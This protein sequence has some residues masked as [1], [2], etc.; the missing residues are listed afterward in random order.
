[1]LYRLSTLLLLAA[2]TWTLP[3]AA[4]TNGA[5][6][7]QDALA[8]LLE[9][10]AT[11]LDDLPDVYYDYY[12]LRSDRDNTV[13]AR[14]AFYNQIG[15]GDSEL[16]KRRSL[17]VELI[18]RRLM[19]EVELGDT[20]IVPTDWDLDMRA[21]SPYPR[22]YPGARSLDKLF[23]IDKTTQAWAAYENGELSR[24][25]PVNTGARESPT[26]AGRYNFN[27][28]EPYRVSSLSPSDE[29][30][31]MY[32]VFNIH[33]ERGIHVHQYAFPTG[34]PTSHGCVR[35]LD[36]D[37]K[38]IYSWADPWKTSGGDGFASSQSRI[39]AAGTTVLV[40][41][42]DPVDRPRPFTFRRRYPILHR[43]ELPA[44]PFD[45]PAGTDQQK[46]WDRER[47]SASRR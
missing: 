36:A 11:S 1:M 46:R 44:D 5:F 31:E 14:N 37:A 10:R 35:L 42:E 3:A 30:W 43:I 25:G 34:G 21:Y 4:Q 9:R 20:L 12:V 15:D 18:N 16:G 19:S 29:P 8:V 26:P 41:G 17:L 13:L 27:W 7:D 47:L 23:I 38:F 32:W 45:V 28:R 2:C 6:F 40:L 24:W 22:Y 39:I 33:N